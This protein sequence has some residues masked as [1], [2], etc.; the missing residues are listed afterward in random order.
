M[1]KIIVF[2]VI[3]LISITIVFP[4]DFPSRLLNQPSIIPLI[5][6]TAILLFLMSITFL[7]NLI[8]KN[9]RVKKLLNSIENRIKEINPFTLYF[10]SQTLCILVF[11]LIWLF[12][13]DNEYPG[14]F[15]CLIAFLALL[16]GVLLTSIFV[17]LFFSLLL[18][19]SIIFVAFLWI[20]FPSIRIS[21]MFSL[22]IE[23]Q[24]Y[25]ANLIYGEG[26]I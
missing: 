26:F 13:G 24:I 14:F 6:G 20:N 9:K 12:S 16:A 3:V 4:L 1:K 2:L 23:K 18:F 17:T 21:S 11:T 7:K 15:I 22:L 8:L 10:L 25:L 5:A 19:L